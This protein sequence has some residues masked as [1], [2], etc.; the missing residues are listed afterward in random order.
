[1]IEFEEILKKRKLDEREK[2]ASLVARD[3]AVID[4]IPADKELVAVHSF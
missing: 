1:L 4:E 2:E 3:K